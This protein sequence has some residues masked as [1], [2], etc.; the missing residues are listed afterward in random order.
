MRT[1]HV[2]ILLIFC[3]LILHNIL[4]A[5]IIYGV[6]ASIS[7]NQSSVYLPDYFS[8]GSNAMQ[9]RLNLLDLKEPVYDVS[10]R[11]R[12]A[13]NGIVLE[14]SPTANIDPITINPGMPVLLSGSDLESYFDKD[15]LIIQGI[16][17]TLYDENKTLPKGSYTFSITAY[18]YNR[19]DPVKVSNAGITGAYLQLMQ[20]PSLISP[21]NKTIADQMLISMR[22]SPVIGMS[23]MLPKYKIEIFELLSTNMPAKDEILTTPPLIEI[24]DIYALN[25]EFLVPNESPQLIEGNRYAWR[26]RAYFDDDRQVIDKGGYSDVN[27]FTYNTVSA[28][29][30]APVNLTTKCT[31]PRL[32]SASWTAVAGINPADSYHLEFRKTGNSSYEWFPEETTETNITIRNLDPDTEYEVRVQAVKDGYMSAYSNTVKVKTQPLKDYEC[33]DTPV[34]EILINQT[35]LMH[36]MIGDYF[37]N[38]DG[39]EF[40]VLSITNA[41]NGTFTGRCSVTLLY[42]GGTYLADFTN[43]RLNTDYRMLAGQVVI[44]EENI[45]EWIAGQA[46]HSTD[47]ISGI[48]DRFTT[49]DAVGHV[50][51]GDV[52]TA[53]INVSVSEDDHATFTENSVT[54]NGQ[55]FDMTSTT[56]G[57]TVSDE[58]GN[59]YAVN[60][61]G[62]VKPIGT[63]G[64]VTT[65]VDYDKNATE[66]T[67]NI[68]T[69]ASISFTNNDDLWAFDEYNEAYSA[70]SDFTRRYEQFNGKYVAWKL[71]PEGKFG[72][73][74]A[75]L[76]GTV[77][78]PNKVV[79]RT[80]K[81]AEFKAEP[82]GNPYEIT[83][84]SGRD[85]DA[86]EIFALYPNEDGTF[87]SLGKLNVATYKMQTHSVNLVPTSA[88]TNIGATALAAQINKIY[89]P[90]GIE[91]TVN[92]E[93]PFTT[94]D[95]QDNKLD[96]DGSGFFSV[97]TDEMKALNEAFKTSGRN[98]DI[99]NPYIFVVPAFNNAQGTLL[100]DMPLDF[101]IGYITPNADNAKLAHTISHELGHGMYQLYHT[102]SDKYNI[103]Q[104]TTTNLMDYTEKGNELVKL[105]WDA[106][107]DPGLKIPWLQGEEEGRDAII[108]FI[109]NEILIN[110]KIY[111]YGSAATQRVAQ[112][113][114]TSI[115]KRWNSQKWTYAVNS[116]KFS[117]TFKI[118]VLLYNN[119]EKSKPSFIFEK[120]D[121]FNRNNYI[122]ICATYQEMDEYDPTI[123]YAQS[124]V[125][126]HDEGQWKFVDTTLTWLWPYA[127]EFGHILGLH[128]AYFTDRNS[129]NYG[130]PI[131]SKYTHNIMNEI[132]FPVEQV[133][134]D[135]LMN[136]I[137]SKYLEYRKNRNSL[138]DA[139]MELSSYGIN[140]QNDVPSQ[141]FIIEINPIK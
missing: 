34:Q 64:T 119:I 118:D 93:E 116:E 73:V 94:F 133:N 19:A 62:E 65:M 77:K 109:E 30:E 91:W 92:V 117:I 59:I 89:L 12:I 122:E 13:G 102:F 5:Q 134:I 138:I 97:Y 113:I 38:K 69:E 35:P 8:P 4:Q 54:V 75:T 15:N 40:H 23:T 21:A 56:G 36:L 39:F 2:S 74:K 66:W 141:K 88:N 49:G 20:A 37:M 105:Q 55:T 121:P 7:V 63:Q 71:I 99:E 139:N 1:K 129:P 14:T 137:I 124:I 140:Y 107:H 128:D 53:A 48:I 10:L 76:S 103:S 79:F 125:Y 61:D 33:A 3:L 81:G 90:Y 114:Q 42:L 131:S 82:N 70:S 111:I 130:K 100:G 135:D 126:G 78:D 67:N 46:H 24:Q 31:S 58:D 123:N 80:P 60:S 72:K 11:L 29:L 106:M 112:I 132:N 83:I 96:A 87:T 104:G 85:G 110:S 115:S 22:W 51:T 127:H 101:Q 9:I 98:I 44:V 25:Y 68:S 41:Q 86:L 18:D 108:T 27:E 95:F 84:P 32:F 45:D 6:Q 26:V 52:S 28:A 17:P 16:N 50:I 136:P 120:Y 47:I 43:V 57:C